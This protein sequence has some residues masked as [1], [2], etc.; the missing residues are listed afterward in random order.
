MDAERKE[1][2]QL[3]Q[4]LLEE[5]KNK[6]ESY[7]FVYQSWDQERKRCHNIMTAKKF[8]EIAEQYELTRQ[9]LALLTID[10]SMQD[11][12]RKGKVNNAET[13]YKHYIKIINKT[14]AQY[15]STSLNP[16]YI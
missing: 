12:F 4:S 6:V 9:Q 7:G 3:K 14:K 15:T 1:L 11:D 8:G 5:I 2:T 10:A 16:T 13:I